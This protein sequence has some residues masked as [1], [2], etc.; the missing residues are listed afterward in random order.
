[1]A[2][3]AKDE[4]PKCKV[5]P[6]LF[7]PEDWHV[8]ENMLDSNSESKLKVLNCECKQVIN[9]FEHLFDP[10]K[11]CQVPTNDKMDEMIRKYQEAR[12]KCTECSGL[13]EQREQSCTCDRFEKL[14]ANVLRCSHG[15]DQYYHAYNIPSTELEWYYQRDRCRACKERRKKRFLCY[16]KW[17]KEGRTF[18]I[19][20]YIPNSCDRYQYWW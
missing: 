15:V 1:M 11:N 10:D 7:K 3:A 2:N 19:Q 17:T 13:D 4:H 14:R 16:R 20:D 12:A 6:L 5:G 8:P 18:R 9:E